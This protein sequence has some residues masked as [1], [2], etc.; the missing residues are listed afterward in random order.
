[1]K[2]PSSLS[3]MPAGRTLD[4]LIAE[5]VMG[6]RVE[7]QSGNSP[8]LV[9]HDG[10]RWT[11]IENHPFSSDIAAAAEMEREIERRS[12]LGNIEGIHV[13]YALALAHEIGF[14]GFSCFGWTDLFRLIRA[15]PVQ[16]CRA[17]LQAVGE[18]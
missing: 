16:R 8:W 3:E 13:R 11:R 12:D 9:G 5:K 2:P 14:P 10:N 4:A 17:A 6:W 7:R 18:P 15:T 1:M